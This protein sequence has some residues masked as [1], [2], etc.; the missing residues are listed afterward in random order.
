MNLL[1]QP[2][3]TASKKKKE[4]KNSLND[5]DIRMRTVN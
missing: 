5:T 4:M 1:L 2:L 3:N